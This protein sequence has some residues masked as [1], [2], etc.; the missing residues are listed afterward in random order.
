MNIN[1]YIRNGNWNGWDWWI[2]NFTVIISLNIR[3]GWE[4]MGFWFIVFIVIIFL[5]IVIMDQNMNKNMISMNTMNTM[6]MNI[7]NISRIL[8]SPSLRLVRT[9]IACAEVYAAGRGKGDLDASEQRRVKQELAED[10]ESPGG[11]AGSFYGVLWWFF[12]GI[13]WFLWWFFR[14]LM[15]FNGIWWSFYG[16]CWDLMGILCVFFDLMGSDGDFNGIW[17]GLTSG[18]RLQCANWKSTIV[19]G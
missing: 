11:K 2:H 14:V 12:R 6:N 16:F 5:F 4:W 18:K 7:R 17:W 10:L 9:R 15:W 19:D 3:N 8:I 1:E 13:S